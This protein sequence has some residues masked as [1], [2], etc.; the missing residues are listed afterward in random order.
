MRYFLFDK[1]KKVGK[2]SARYALLFPLMLVACASSNEEVLYIETSTSIIKVGERISLTAQATEIFNSPPEWEVMELEGGSLM[3]TTG[4]QVTYLAPS[5]AG[6]YRV[7]AKAVRANG[8]KVR[9]VQVILVQ[10]Q[11]VI[12]PASVKL[13]PGETYTFNVK[14][15]G[16]DSAKIQWSIDESNGGS[17]TQTGLYTAPS[18]SGYYH[19]V[20]T[21][22]TDGQPSALASVRVE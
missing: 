10:P 11:L 4:H 20:A 22:Q 19:V 15:K 9:A 13:A 16:I 2:T 5:Y 1:T 8:Q 14:I 6:T 12:E 3:R 21:A 18:N 17:I 7:I